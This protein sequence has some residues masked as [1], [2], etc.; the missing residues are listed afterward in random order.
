MG[1]LQ[2][3]YRLTAIRVPPPVPKGIEAALARWIGKTKGG[4][5][6]LRTLLREAHAI[7]QA[8]EQYR[9]WSEVD[10]QQKLQELRVMVRA[11]PR[12]SS[13]QFPEALAL[14]QESVQR[15]LGYR[16][17]PVQLAGA[18]AL[19]HGYIAEMSTGE[20]KTVTAAMAAV[21]RG[22]TGLPCHVI[23]A[24]DYLAAR[25]AEIM[26]SLFAFCGV[27]VASVTSSL[28]PEER[29]AAY[30]QDVVYTT[31]KEILADFLRDRIALGKM[32]SFE[33]R[34]IQSFSDQGKQ[35]AQG[36][37][38]RGI[39]TAII[40]EADNVLIDE[41]V[42]PLIIS[43]EE[44]NDAFMESCKT[45]ILIADQLKK[46]VD[47]Q[48]DT[49]FRT[50]LFLRD[51][52]EM[53]EAAQADNPTR[54]RG[55]LFQKDLIRQALVAKEFFIRD[56]QYV[57]EEE[58]VVIVDESTGR[59]MPMRSWS[60]GLHQLVEA[61]EGLPM[62]PLKE[63]QA[64]LSF[65]RFFRFFQQ[66]SGM[67]G[68][69]KEATGEFW[70]IYN[71]AVVRIPNNRPSQRKT[72]GLRFSGTHA[73]K[74]KQILAEIERVHATGR[75]ILVGTRTVQQSEEFAE[76]IRYAGLECRVVNAL[77]QEEEASIIALAGDRDAIT[78]A[79][80][81][82]GR[83]TDIKLHREVEALGGLH[84]IATECHGSSRIDRQLFGRSAR[85]GDRGSAVPFAS[86]EDDL[87]SRNTPRLFRKALWFFVK[88]NPLWD[89]LL[90]SIA[91]HF[92]QWIAHRKD[93]Q[94]RISVQRTD[95]WLD[96]SLSFA[97]DDVK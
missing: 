11:A 95:T 84:V 38:M 5:K 48:L 42:T 26:G 61:K 22:W 76:L 62:S 29:R 83:G 23:T 60:A 57:V 28:K 8:A 94:S 97:P 1:A 4:R 71:V 14:I 74:R 51:I 54:F 3:N 75:P 39:H 69:A 78:V 15:T 17:Y 34:M 85:Q 37:V 46:D 80:N 55:V 19:L 79:T 36:V 59:K 13:Q 43:R 63:T 64:R 72:L 18:L 35:A 49:T 50:V 66:F 68:T 33:K 91:V 30:A 32:Q 9:D 93:F 41:A 88:I 77:R 45:A 21:I 24:N 58:K 2:D 7:D 67:T 92:A 65:Q 25:D 89:S 81:M 73:H 82:A 96:E 90:G 12:K 31:P 27:R 86:L 44:P 20:G 16:P 53:I 70:Q 40:D 56:R 10:L 52:H 47:Y 6:V 87:L